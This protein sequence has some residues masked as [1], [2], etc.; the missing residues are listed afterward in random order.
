MKSLLRLLADGHVHS[1]QSL[2]EALG[3]S[4]A[5]IWKQLARLEA[6]G[7]SVERIRRQGYCLPSPLELLDAD[8]IRMMVDPAAKPYL[9][10]MYIHDETGSTNAWLMGE[11]V[12]G[13]SSGVVCLAESQS[14]GRGRRG[15]EW[16]SPYA[17]NIYI[18]FLWRYGSGATAL[19]GLSLAAGVMALEA[20]QSQGVSG[21]SLKWPNDVMAGERKLGGILLEMGGDPAGEC[22][23]V[24]GIGINM[25][26]PS[27]AA[28]QIGQP[29]TDVATVTGR[30]VSRNAMVAALVSHVLPALAAYEENGFSL[31]RSRWA[32]ADACQSMPVRVLVGETV[33]VG[34]GA[35]VDERGAFRLQTDAGVETFH[36]GE[37]S[38]RIGQ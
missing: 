27:L 11:A 23:V 2:G 26:M 8:A 38:L 18:S 25:H 36:G 14:Q 31:F 13:M 12:K 19:E 37:I 24:L 35:G 16:V 32:Q 28:G 15:R 1:G 29:W 21:L 9:R 33:H 34:V 4:R 22:F 3:V 20:L 17:S 30:P 10:D 6:S 7:V 5:A